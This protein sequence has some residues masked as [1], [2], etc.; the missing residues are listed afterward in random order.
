MDP[1]PLQTLLAR[2]AFSLLARD[3]L[4]WGVD[5]PLQEASSTSR[6]NLGSQWAPPFSIVSLVFLPFL[7]HPHSFFNR[8]NSADVSLAAASPKSCQPLICLRWLRHTVMH[9]PF[10]L[11]HTPPLNCVEFNEGSSWRTFKSAPLR[12][13]VCISAPGLNF[14]KSER[15]S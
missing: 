10:I 12:L 5:F 1:P 2:V 15:S 4:Q 8:T 3:H 7:F 6:G 13:D 14:T 11:A 9:L